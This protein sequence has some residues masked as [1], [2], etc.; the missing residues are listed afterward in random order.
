MIKK[1]KNC[2]G[3][4]L[5]YIY[6]RFWYANEIE[7]MV[8]EDWERGMNERREEHGNVIRWPVIMTPLITDNYC[9][10]RPRGVISTG[11]SPVSVATLQRY[12]YTYHGEIYLHMSVY[13]ERKRN[14]E[15][16]LLYESNGIN[17]ISE[18]NH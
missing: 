16:A 4:D 1:K 7:Q 3:K 8:K 10:Y 12:T 17:E 18:I 11:P 15:R 6:G 13:I 5:V 9:S 14:N 2:D